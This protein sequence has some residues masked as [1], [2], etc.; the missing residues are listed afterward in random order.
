MQNEPS[1]F[2]LLVLDMTCEKFKNKKLSKKKK[3]IYFKQIKK[4]N[5]ATN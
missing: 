3:D 2:N 5:K 1:F 4:K